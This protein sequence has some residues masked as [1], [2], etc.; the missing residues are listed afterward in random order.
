VEDWGGGGHFGG[1]GEEV[2]WGGEIGVYM[3]YSG[4]IWTR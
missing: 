2:G 3:V 4:F 1:F